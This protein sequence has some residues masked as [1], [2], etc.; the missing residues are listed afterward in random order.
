MKK[1][2][3]A[4]AL[5][6]V[7][8]FTGCTN[9]QSVGETTNPPV[10]PAITEPRPQS[11]L[12]PPQLTPAEAALQEL[13]EREFG[14][15]EFFR[16]ETTDQEIF[17]RIIELRIDTDSPYADSDTGRFILKKGLAADIDFNIRTAEEAIRRRDSMNIPEVDDIW[18]LYTVIGTFR[19]EERRQLCDETFVLVGF[20]ADAVIDGFMLL[21]DG[22][23]SGRIIERLD[24]NPHIFISYNFD[25]NAVKLWAIG[26]TATGQ[27]GYIDWF[28]LEGFELD[29][30]PLPLLSNQTRYSRI[31]YPD[32]NPNE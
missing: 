23:H 7:I 19:R 8:F 10:A 15:T 27:A 1:I 24:S 30:S 18:I 3:I 16:A 21:P 2:L 28:V 5:L 29:R 26:E 25:L 6:C 31:F 22:T 32:T 17:P 9:T 4:L 20:I 12:S 13:W 14:Y 11:P